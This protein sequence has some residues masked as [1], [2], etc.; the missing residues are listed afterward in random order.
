MVE[1]QVKD[2][3]A[4]VHSTSSISKGR[5]YPE[6][7]DSVP[8]PKGF[9]PPSFKNFDGTG[10]PKQHLAHFR[11]SCCNAGGSDALLFRQFV[12]SLSWIAFDWYAELPNGSV[13][14]FNDLEAMFVKRFAGAKHHITVG[15]LV[16]E[17]QKPGES[18][19]DYI[20][21]W[22][23]LSMRC[24]PQLQEKHAIEILL[25]NIHS[26]VAFLLK[27]FTIKTFEKL[28]N[29]ASNLQEEVSQ[30][31]FAKDS[32][33]LEMKKLKPQ[34]VLEKKSGTVS[35][36][37]KGKQPMQIQTENPNRPPQYQQYNRPQGEQQTRPRPYLTQEQQKEKFEFFMKKVY[38]FKREAIKKMFK[39][40]IKKPGFKLPE[41]KRPEEAAKA[42]QPNFFSYHRMSGH[43]LEDCIT[44]KEWLDKNHKD[45]TVV[46]PKEY[47]VDP[48]QGS[49]KCIF[50]VRQQKKNKAPIIE[51]KEVKADQAP[52]V[53]EK[54]QKKES[55]L[56]SDKLVISENGEH[57]SLKPLTLYD[58]YF[59]PPVAKKAMKKDS[60]YIMF[61]SAD[62]YPDH[63]INNNENNSQDINTNETDKQFQFYYDSDSPILD[64][65]GDP[66][67]IELELSD[68]DAPPEET[69]TSTK[70]QPIKTIDNASSEE[71]VQVNLRSGKILPP[72]L[73]STG[74]EKQITDNPEIANQP[75]P[76]Q[77]PELENTEISKVDY[78]VLAHLRKL[79]AKLSIYDALV[80]SKEM[81]EA[82]VKALL[83]PEI[84]IAQ[85]ASTHSDEEA[86]YFKEVPGVTFSDED[87][88]LGTADH[89][90]PLYIS[91]T[92]DNFKVSRVLV[93]PGA[94]VNIMALKIL[95]YLRVDTRKLSSDKMMLRGFNEKGERALGSITLAF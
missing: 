73:A 2:A 30:L 46:I 27:G 16:V 48:S 3:L 81:R 21:R 32:T 53:L 77:E 64:V 18:L 82:L 31:P 25:K 87:L 93:D 91:V 40:L 8:Y 58:F 55:E 92:I 22:I 9:V 66:I 29:K 28:L 44:F 12:S 45:G 57:V 83:D 49:A 11:A 72:R 84:C 34:K 14:T 26:P 90:R 24:E 50:V 6:E 95:A 41:S 65:E 75:Q 89:N 74:K 62:E 94:S 13:H 54:D 59:V 68:S 1:Q 23:N 71:V 76:F 60:A 52:L 80:L 35:A 47:L 38:P 20:L 43:E 61:V 4:K 70:D 63:N 51:P 33:S 17:T 5:P 10:N 88:L 86:L 42:G 36:V 19:V 78:N 79:P 7:F 15:D 37:D 85:L 69:Q 56:D 39:S 67:N